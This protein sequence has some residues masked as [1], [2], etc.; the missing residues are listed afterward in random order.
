MPASHATVIE[1]A[2]LADGLNDL[3]AAGY[4]RFSGAPRS[5]GRTTLLIEEPSIA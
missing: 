2:G 3:D 1:D 5:Q 4:R